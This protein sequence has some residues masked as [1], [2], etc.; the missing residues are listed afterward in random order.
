[1]KFKTLSFAVLTS[2][3]LIGCGG[4][5]DSSNSTN[6]NANGSNGTQPNTQITQWSNF[7]ID[8]DYANNLQVNTSLDLTSAEFNIVNGKLYAVLDNYDDQEI[9][10]TTSG[11]YRSM[12]P[13]HS[14]YGGLLGDITVQNDQFNIRPYSAINSTGLIFTQD[15]KKIDISGKPMLV[16]VDPHLN[17]NV[18]FPQI[19][20]V[21]FDNALLSKLRD[22]QKTTFPKGSICLQ[23]RKYTNNQRYLTLL[24]TS[25]NDK[26]TFDDYSSYYLNNYNYVK[27]TQYFNSTAYLPSYDKTI[28]NAQDGVANYQGQYYQA[29][30]DH[31]GTEYDL[32]MNI[33]DVKDI[34]NGPNLSAEV[35]AAYLSYAN[36][37]NQGCDLYNDVAI[38]FLKQNFK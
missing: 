8:Y 20:T 3:S 15:N 29:Y 2:L 34:A 23:E 13:I 26:Q 10:L 30:L 28:E 16:T 21:K 9:Y 5:S 37:L 25:N 17:W 14:Q 33:K 6:Q 24:Q 18:N 11:E 31:K 36:D 35:K 7:R 32:A 19:T 1:M 27:L 22:Y 38:Q 12:G 4:G